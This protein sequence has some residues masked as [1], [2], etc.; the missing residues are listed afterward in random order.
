M[1]TIV[2]KR[3]KVKTCC[4]P[5]HG[6][7]P[8]QFWGLCCSFACDRWDQSRSPC[9]HADSA[10][11]FRDPPLHPG[12]Y[13]RP[14]LFPRCTAGFLYFNQHWI[15]FSFIL[16]VTCDSANKYI[17]DITYVTNS[18]RN[19]ASVSF[20]ILG[21]E[22]KTLDSGGEIKLTHLLTQAAVGHVGLGGQIHRHFWGK[23]HQET[24]D[25]TSSTS[26]NL[27]KI[28]VG[29]CYTIWGTEAENI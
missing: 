9:I 25:Q 1:E 26:N 20:W 18:F 14:L 10:H 16:Q 27:T 12:K 2:N 19:R 3:C 6:N 15:I 22:R 17:Q 4:T 23:P 21:A 7:W 11:P 28:S 8:H 24:H 13:L 5:H 29:H